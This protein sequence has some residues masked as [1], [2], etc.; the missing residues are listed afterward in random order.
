MLQSYN[1][2]KSS[3]N[4]SVSA[5]I[6]PIMHF[7]VQALVAQNI[8]FHFPLWSEVTNWPDNFIST[9]VIIICN[10]AHMAF[11]HIFGL[12]GHHSNN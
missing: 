9:H 2:L 11:E 7:Y 12:L 5:N 10:V 8:A 1:S 4:G 6:N 3:Q